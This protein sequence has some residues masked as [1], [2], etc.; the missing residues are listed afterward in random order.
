MALGVAMGHNWHVLHETC[1]EYVARR[2]AFDIVAGDAKLESPENAKI[3]TILKKRLGHKIK[4]IG[5]G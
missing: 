3:K 1:R 5:V 2:L 4:Y